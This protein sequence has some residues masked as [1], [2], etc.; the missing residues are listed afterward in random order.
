MF[1]VTKPA[2][3]RLDITLSGEL[4]TT[5]MRQAL[6][7]LLAQSEG[8]AGGRMLYRISDFQM[9]TA[10]ALAIEM[11]YLPQLFGLVGRFDRCAVV[12]DIEWMRSVAEVKGALIPGLEIKAFADADEAAAETWL[13][14]GA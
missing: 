7:D 14:G 10:G 12:T 9:P 3:N 11:T 8:I 13:E 6:D 1:T 4:D 2:S 5:A